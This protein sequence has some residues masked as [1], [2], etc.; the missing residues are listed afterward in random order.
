MT[1]YI[2]SCPRSESR[3]DRIARAYLDKYSEEFDEVFLPSLN[4][5]PLCEAALDKR[6]K[7]IEQ[8]DFSDSMFDLAKQFQSADKIVISAPFWDLSFPAI[9]KIYIEN[10]FVNGIVF[11]YGAN[12]IPKGLCKAR[13]IVYV[14]TA[15][16][17][18]I[19][20][21]S[22]GYIE[23]IAKNYLGIPQ[24]TLIK[25]EML[26]VDGFDAEKIVLDVISNL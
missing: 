26:D 24:T 1:L 20:D 17:P 23:G 19:P 8:G 14:T 2:N 21:Y 7:L 15:G 22:F 11:E 6:T 18:Y 9:L 10:I 13:E 25:A 3:T 5:K 12:G 16:G 4:L